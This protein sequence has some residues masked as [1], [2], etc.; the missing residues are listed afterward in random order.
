MFY[1][2]VCICDFFQQKYFLIFFSSKIFAQQKCEKI[3]FSENFCQ[4]G[5][6]FK[7][8]DHFKWKSFLAKIFGKNYFFTFLLS[9][10]FR[11][12]KYQK[13]FLLKKITNTYTRV[14][15]IQRRAS[16]SSGARRTSLLLKKWF[17]FALILISR[18]W[19]ISVS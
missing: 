7:M 5:F 13:I 1:S 4:E 19:G 12:K 2:S 11:R 18:P 15:H 8:V 9:K 6:S 16:N 14:K 17:F 10:N 3:I